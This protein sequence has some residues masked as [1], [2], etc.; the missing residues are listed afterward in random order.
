MVKKYFRP[1][2][3]A[4]AL[5]VSMGAQAP[6]MVLASEPVQEQSEKEPDVLDDNQESEQESDS[7]DESE[8]E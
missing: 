4:A 2:I 1:F 8:S 7:E 3:L 5:S 6:M